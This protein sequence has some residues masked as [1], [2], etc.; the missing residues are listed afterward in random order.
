MPEN[1]IILPVGDYLPDLPDYNAGGANMILNVYPRTP[2]SYGPIPS[3]SVYSSALSSRCQ[4]SVAIIDPT[5]NIE[6][7]AG[8]A[9]K[10]YELTSGS[11]TWADVS[12]VGGYSTPSDIQWKFEQ[13]N[14]F[15]TATN[16]ADPIQVFQIGTSTA[17]AD[18]S[19]DA[20]K[21]K[22]MAF[23]KGF[24]VVANTT[25]GTFGDQPQRVWWP[26]LN[27]PTN[28]P[29][30]G[31]TA[32]A[33]V[34]SSYNDVFGTQGDI[35]GLVGNLGNA[36]AAVFFRFAV[37]R[38]VYSGPPNTFDFFPAEGVRGCPA[39]NS[40]VQFGNL[41]FYLG[42]DG[43]YSFD[44]MNSRP[45]GANKVDLTFYADVDQSYMDRIIGA[46]DPQ[47][48]Q[49]LWAYPGTGSSN[50]IPNKILIYNWNIDK[51]SLAEITC[52][53]ISRLL[54]LGYTL[55][56]LYTV[57]G[58]LLDDVPASLDS[59]LWIGGQI[60]LS[61]FDTSH[62]LN[63]FTGPNLAATVDTSESQLFSG[64]K[65]RLKNARAIVDGQVVPSVAISFRDRQV[66]NRSY[67][68]PIA[69]NS[70]GTSPVRCSGRYISG[71]ITLPA[72]S[73]FTNITGL[74][75]EATVAGTR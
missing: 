5:L 34:Q 46:A 43:F 54:T 55:D 16:Y 38:M 68:S 3:P 60:I 57:L 47:R 19:A 72:N 27:D 67:T 41:C 49:I 52:E 45:I 28:W 18:L 14:G 64:R 44:G 8:D 36:D 33:Q 42:E 12:K 62:R 10:L 66:D 23:V 15:V 24:L 7:F 30:P 22:Y 29:T 2:T 56:E 20:P 75:L 59:P 37:W 65:A 31:S 53:N 25:D 74:E 40:I 21:A 1:P 26:A 17:F 11:N 32:A 58:Y 61:M 50:G 63:F 13:Y 71:R 6:L 51:W 69:M 9:S 4:G 35:H 39:P 70:L 73:D 48:K